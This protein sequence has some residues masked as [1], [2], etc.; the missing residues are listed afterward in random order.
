VIRPADQN[1]ISH[2]AEVRAVARPTSARD[3]ASVYSAVCA[4]HSWADMP[5]AAATTVP[6]AVDNCGDIAAIN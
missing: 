2:A 5:T 1:L 4:S 3:A 6:V